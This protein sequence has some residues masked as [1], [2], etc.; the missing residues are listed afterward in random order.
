MLSR[1]AE[2]AVRAVVVLAREYGVRAL[3]AEKLASIVGAPRN[4]LSKTLNVLAR[5]GLLTSAR[6]PGGGFSLAVSPDVITVADIV[7]VFTDANTPGTRCLLRNAPCDPAHPCSS[8]QRWTELTAAGSEPLMRTTV[9][10]LRDAKGATADTAM[11]TRRSE[12][13]TPSRKERR[14]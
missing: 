13:R 10:E 9:G 3:S 14:R 12:V 6:G 5:R 4:Y 2:H 1:T 11:M 8:H 7:E